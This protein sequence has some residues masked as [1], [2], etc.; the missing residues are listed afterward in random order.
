MMNDR[1]IALI[2]FLA[3]SDRKKFTEFSEKTGIEPKHLKNL[4][5]KRQRINQDHITAICTA[6]PQYKYWLVF[7][8]VQPD[9]GQISPDLEETRKAYN[10]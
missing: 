4:Y 7:G 9:L 5:H 6:Y 10:G 2:D 1:L 3:T 8:E